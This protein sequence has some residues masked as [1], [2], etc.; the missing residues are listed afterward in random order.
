MK[1]LR[2]DF[3]DLDIEIDLTVLFFLNDL[4]SV[5][6]FNIWLDSAPNNLS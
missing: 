1:F 2:V 3:F 5:V 4:I 6:E